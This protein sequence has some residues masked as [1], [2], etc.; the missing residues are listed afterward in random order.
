MQSGR[1]QR[2]TQEERT[3]L[4]D[5]RMLD[6]AVSLLVEAGMAGT[7]LAAIGERSGYSRGLVTHR[8]GSKAGLFAHVHDT[9]MADWIARVHEAV[10][11]AV[12][13]DALQRV[14]DALYGFIA[15]A[16]DEIRAMYLLRYASIDPSAEF[17]ASVARAHL[18]QR[19]DVQRWIAAG[20]C[21]GG[22][23]PSMDAAEVAE[24]FCACVDGVIYRW[25]VTPDIPVRSLHELLKQQVDTALR[26]RAASG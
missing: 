19:R 4:S 2:R 17:R 21:D 6:A 22:I 13:L 12:G 5:R 9:V 8:F 24:L 16:P 25:L 1:T 7:T 10:G 23:D 26:V 11:A 20:Q 15:E 18:A 14:V 3:A